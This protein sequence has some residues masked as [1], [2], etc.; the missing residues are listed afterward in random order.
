MPPRA[1][2]L[3][4]IHY[5]GAATGYPDNFFVDATRVVA[6]LTPEMRDVLSNRT[7]T[8][9]YVDGKT[10]VE[11]VATARTLTFDENG[12][13]LRVVWNEHDRVAGSFDATT[14]RA[15]VAFQAL[16]LRPDLHYH[17][18]LRPGEAVL[19]DNWRVLHARGSYDGQLRRRVVGADFPNDHLARKLQETSRPNKS[20]A[21]TLDST[22]ADTFLGSTCRE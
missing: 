1:K 16:A 2:L 19:V 14:Q 21:D 10:G 22:A 18:E 3:H 17:F 12:A 7:V 8:T 9:R 20:A 4:C 11:S 6:A 13:L 5:S 15:L